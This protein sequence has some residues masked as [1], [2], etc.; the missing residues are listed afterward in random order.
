MPGLD[1]LDRLAH[2][3]DHHAA[4]L[5]I[6]C[7]DA[8][9]VEILAHLAE[10]VVVAGFL[11]VGHH[12]FLGIGVRVGALEAELLG[13][14]KPEQLVAPGRRLEL[15]LLV[16]RELLLETF[17]TLVE[18]GHDC[19]AMLLPLLIGAILPPC[20]ARHDGQGNIV[21]TLIRGAIDVWNMSIRF[22]CAG[23]R[24]RIGCLVMDAWPS[25]SLQ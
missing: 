12:D 1:L 3:L 8:L 19:L 2:Q 5:L 7:G 18:R 22:D 6:G 9:G 25:Q 10:D 14:P 24:D 20:I 13:G 23:G 4:D 21:A 17:L 16:M 15:Q 11:E